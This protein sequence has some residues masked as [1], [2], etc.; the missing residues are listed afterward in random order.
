MFP[1]NLLEGV[2]IMNGCC[3]F[4]SACIDMTVCVGV[5][6]KCLFIFERQRQNVSG[7]GAEREGNTEF[8]SGSR[9]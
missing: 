1:V 7:V 8:E 3:T 5:F 6:L 2:T 4:F 9:L